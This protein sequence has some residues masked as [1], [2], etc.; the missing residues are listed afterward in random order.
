METMKGMRVRREV[1][2]KQDLKNRLRSAQGHM[3]AIADMIDNDADCMDILRQVSAVRG[4]VRAI[5]RELWQ[6]YLLDEECR[7]RSDS[8]EQRVRAWQELEALVFS[9]PAD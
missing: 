6:A 5:H 3:R 7:L 2:D 4:A 8:E 1:L 9:T